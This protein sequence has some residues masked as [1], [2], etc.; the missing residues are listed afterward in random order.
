MTKTG[1]ILRRVGRV[2][3]VLT[4]FVAVAFVAAKTP[5]FDTFLESRLKSYLGER[6]VVFEAAGFDFDPAGPSLSLTSLKIDGPEG[7][8]NFSSDTFH[9]ELHLFRSFPGRPLLSLEVDGPALSG[10]FPSS[11]GEG[12]RGRGVQGCCQ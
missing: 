10:R 6:G 4:A 9:A 5:A 12:A 1:K 7:G 11:G 2:L 8:W 3:F